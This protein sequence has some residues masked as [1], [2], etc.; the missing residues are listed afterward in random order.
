MYVCVRMYIYTNTHR[1]VMHCM[2]IH[3]C[4]HRSTDYGQTFVNESSK[5]PPQTV[6]D[7]TIYRFPNTNAVSVNCDQISKMRLYT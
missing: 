4:S 3:T 6:L 2:Y 1:V 7:N 5:F